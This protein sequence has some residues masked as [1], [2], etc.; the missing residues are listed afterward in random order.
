MTKRYTPP[1]FEKAVKSHII[2]WKSR[3]TNPALEVPPIMVVAGSTGTGKTTGIAHICAQMGAPLYPVEGK[4]LVASTEGQATAPLV[5]EL[6]KAA[7]DPTALVPCVLID[8]ADLGGLGTSPNI[9][10]TVN[11]E[12]VKG[13]VMTW[14]DKPDSILVEQLNRA[15]S[16]IP[17]KRSACMFMTTNRLDHLHPP[18]IRAGRATIFVLDPQGEELERTVAGI[19]PQLTL[20]QAQQL[21]RRFS[22]QP[23]AFFPDIKAELAKDA[24]LQCADHYNGDL[25][26]ADWSGVGDF[27]LK[28]SNGA[29]YQDLVAAG[30][31]L[32]GTSRDT[33]F[34]TPQKPVE[35]PVRRHSGMNGS[36]P[37][38]NGSEPQTASMEA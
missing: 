7:N 37:Y 14:A 4:N 2:L 13:C 8:D 11:G 36:T 33:N 12:A 22:G 1:D 16:I 29:S 38:A 21:V 6:I 25:Q 5:N 28:H 31:K 20:R 23:V 19:F 15:P 32:A 9:T 17:L 27:I 3:E 26:G 18:M 30:D 24:A 10:G 34:I 35:A